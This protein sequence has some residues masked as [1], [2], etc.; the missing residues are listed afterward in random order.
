MKL[1][2]E[3]C[4][5]V[6]LVLCGH[7]L[8]VQCA[9]VALSKPGGCLAD[10]T[11]I[12]I[13]S[14]WEVSGLSSRINDINNGDTE[15]KKHFENREGC[16]PPGNDYTEYRLYPSI[17]DANRIVKSGYIYYFTSDHYESFYKIKM[18]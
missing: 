9:S 12:P 15:S 18:Y 7:I 16:L 10:R 4:Y 17:A 1:P 13:I 3:V 8:A 5:A 2:R 14:T 11:S 6:M